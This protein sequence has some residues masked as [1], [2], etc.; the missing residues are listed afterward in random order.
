MKRIDDYMT[1]QPTTVTLDDPASKIIQIFEDNSFDHIPVLNENNELEGIIS[2]VD[3]YIK[4]LS[5]SKTS[6]GKTYSKK[7]LDSSTAQDIMTA[8]PVTINYDADPLEAINLFLD[9]NYHALPVLKMKQLV[10]ILSS[11]D[12]IAFVDEK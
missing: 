11:K 4:L 1:Y 2:K 8:N 10:G 5:L 6:T 12:L 7:I 9:G 3:I